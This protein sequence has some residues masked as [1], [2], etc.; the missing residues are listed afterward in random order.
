MLPTMKPAVADRMR[1]IIGGVLFL[2]GI[3]SL[4]VSPLPPR[5]ALTYALI[6]V[7]CGALWILNNEPL[8]WVGAAVL[9]FGTQYATDR[10]PPT[11]PWW[12]PTI[13][14]AGALVA[15]YF[16]PLVVRRLVRR[17]A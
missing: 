13:I 12:Q 9:V 1:H 16:A 14:A 5:F 3:A 17:R 8:S 6:G 7:V 2:V 10:A 15:V 11:V 4:F